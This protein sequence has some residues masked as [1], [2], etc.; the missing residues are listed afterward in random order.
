MA[1]VVAI[2]TALT[3]LGFSAKAS[4]FITDNQ[5]LDALDELKGITNDEIESLCKVVRC[6]GG[7]VPNPNP[8]DPGQP[9]TLSNPGEQVPLRAELNLKL[10]C[11]YHRLKDQTSCVVGS[12]EINLDNVCELRIHRDWE[13]SHKDVDAPDMSLRDWSRNIESIG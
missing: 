7:T 4:G 12:P 9:A 8:G 13:K 10:A 3:R 5:G 11:Y 2:C 1:D 6:P